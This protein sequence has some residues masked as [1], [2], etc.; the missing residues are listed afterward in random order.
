MVQVIWVRVLLLMVV[1][2]YLEL[3]NCAYSDTSETR[4]IL[5]LDGI[6]NCYCERDSNESLDY[7]EKHGLR[8]LNGIVK[9][10]V[11]GS[12]IDFDPKSCPRSVWYERSF[13]VPK[14]WKYERIILIRLDGLGFDTVLWLNGEIIERSNKHFEELDVTDRLVYDSENRIA[15]EVQNSPKNR[16]EFQEIPRS[17]SLLSVPEI[18]YIQ[19]ISVAS[20]VTND[21]AFISYKAIAGGLLKINAKCV[22]VQVLD[23][24]DLQVAFSLG[25]DSLEGSFSIPNF[26][27]WRPFCMDSNRAGYLYTLVFKLYY[28]YCESD[29]KDVYRMKIGIRPLSWSNNSLTMNDKSLYLQGVRGS[30]EWAVSF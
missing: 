3:V 14:S 16:S 19:S 29:I 7:R 23:K 10:P 20:T 9:M 26:N 1:I 17:I 6:W 25:N 22:S 4:E 18:L 11:P 24:D 2:G 27:Y 5:H 13:F 30:N 12:L 8:K 21:T 15:L 28:K